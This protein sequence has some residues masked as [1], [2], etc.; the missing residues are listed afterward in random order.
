MHGV[1]API[2]SLWLCSKRAAWA[3]GACEEAMSTKQETGNC[4]VW[5]W[6]NGESWAEPTATTRHC[7]C[8]VYTTSFIISTHN[9]RLR[10]GFPAVYPWREG[11][12]SASVGWG[13]K[14]EYSLP[15]WT[16]STMTRDGQGVRKGQIHPWQP[17]TS[18]CLFDIAHAERLGLANSP[19]SPCL[20]HT[21][22][23]DSTHWG[24]PP[25]PIY[26]P[27]CILRVP[28]RVSHL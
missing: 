25:F 26:F 1:C 24:L 10:K 9:G 23:Q 8:H 21:F 13:F 16:L 12:T 6:V 4:G 11:Y 14:K 20:Q 19:M 7:G 27:A 3:Q 2:L 15:Q 5:K 28:A 18:V 17:G 22:T